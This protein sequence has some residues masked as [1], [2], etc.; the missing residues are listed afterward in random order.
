MELTEDEEKMV[1]GGYGEATRRAMEILVKMGE[2]SGA[3]RMVPVSW[4]DLSTFSGIGGGH[5][6]SP[7]ND[8]YKFMKEMDDLCDRENVRFRCPTVLADVGDPEET[9]D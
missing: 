7:D 1:S 4:A 8:L 3:K 2:Y 9:R 5:G 6:D